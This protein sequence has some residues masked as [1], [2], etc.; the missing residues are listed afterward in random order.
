MKYYIKSIVCK[1]IK[2]IKFLTEK[3]GNRYQQQY[4]I[5]LKFNSNETQ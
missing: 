3:V 5:K 2:T 1:V 4:L